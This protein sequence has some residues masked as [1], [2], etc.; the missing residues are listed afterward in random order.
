MCRKKHHH[1]GG[2]VAQSNAVRRLRSKIVCEL[3]SLFKGL[4]RSSDTAEI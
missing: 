4:S 2:E 1:G 3:F